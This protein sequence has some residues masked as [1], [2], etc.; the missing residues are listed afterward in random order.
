M[1]DYYKLLGVAKTA[2]LNEVKKAYHNLA[3]KFH[4]DHNPG[5]T[6]IGR[7]F[8]MILEA[9]EVLHDTESRKFYDRY[10]MRKEALERATR[11]TPGKR[12]EGV[13][14]SV[15]DEVLGAGK[16]K[17]RSGKDHR[18]RLEIT[19]EESLLGVT[20]EIRILQDRKCTDCEGSGALTEE[21]S[22]TCHVCDGSGEARLLDSSLIPFK[23]VCSFCE[24]QGVIVLSACIRCAGLGRHLEEEGFEVP[25][26]QGVADGKRLRIRGGGA[27]GEFGGKS[28]DL[29]VELKIRKHRFFIPQ[30]RNLQVD[31]PVDIR[32][33]C[34][35]AKVLA[36]TLRGSIVVHVPPGTQEGDL[37]RIRG[38]GLPGK[39][40]KTAGDLLLKV[41]LELP[42]LD[43]EQMEVLT[44]G[45]AD[46]PRD[47]HPKRNAFE[48]MIKERGKELNGDDE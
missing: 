38:E 10:G 12:F 4:P 47:S 17:S 43:P 15:V 5:N 44:R 8:Q 18:Y 33:A 31:F 13:V 26:P 30:E 22:G 7:Q 20:K 6:G 11:P 35:G 27:P 41:H 29:Y 24:G 9:Y 37:L 16:R 39:G 36:P 19:L 2:P 28:G 25:V 3:L 48:R 34:I 21:D 23:R 32:A 42:V 1:A 46:I 45:W 40:K 14:E